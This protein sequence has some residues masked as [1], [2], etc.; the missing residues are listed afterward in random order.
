M[1]KIDYSRR[2]DVQPRTRDILGT[3]KLFRDG[4]PHWVVNKDNS[5][6]KTSDE[7]HDERT[8]LIKRLEK[9]DRSKAEA[10]ADRLASCGP[11]LSYF[12]CVRPGVPQ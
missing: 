4:P 8:S 1:P 6:A 3:K 12:N 10:V 5:P 11:G 2:P 9:S 7:A